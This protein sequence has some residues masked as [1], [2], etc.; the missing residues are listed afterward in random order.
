MVHCGTNMNQYKYAKASGLE[1]DWNRVGSGLE[2]DQRQTRSELD[3][4]W[5]RSVFSKNQVSYT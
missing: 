4:K 1:L 3:Q 5:T 2:E